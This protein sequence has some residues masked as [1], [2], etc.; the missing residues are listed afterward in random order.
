MSGMLIM[1]VCC[2]GRYTVRVNSAIG[3][4]VIG[5]IFRDAYHICAQ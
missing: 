5:K 4:M 1:G 2:V 3:I